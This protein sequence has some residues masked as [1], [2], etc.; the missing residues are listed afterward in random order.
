MLL[1]PI[2]RLEDIPLIEQP[3]TTELLQL[4]TPLRMEV[5]LLSKAMDRHRR[6]HLRVRGTKEV[7]NRSLL[8][9]LRGHGEAITPLA[10]VS[11]RIMGRTVSRRGP[12]LS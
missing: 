3:L 5:R 8:L 6:I 10:L 12:C 9:M 1:Q 2:H 4:A 7:T 11:L